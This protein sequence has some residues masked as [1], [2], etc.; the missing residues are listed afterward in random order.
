M[1]VARLTAMNICKRGMIFLGKGYIST[2]V[3]SADQRVHYEAS[4]QRD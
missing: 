2:A 3:P 4:D 1:C